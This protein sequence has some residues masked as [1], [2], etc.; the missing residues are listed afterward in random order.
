MYSEKLPLVYAR[1]VASDVWGALAST[2]KENYVRALKKWMEFAS[3]NGVS[4]VDPKPEFRMS[5]V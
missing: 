2:T 3:T 4:I 5:F 1:G